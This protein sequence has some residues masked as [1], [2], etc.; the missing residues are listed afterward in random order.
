MESLANIQEIRR[1]ILETIAKPS[2]GYSIGNLKHTVIKSEDQNRFLVVRT[3]WY[4]GKNYYGIM[5]DI[6]LQD[7][8]VLIHKNG[9]DEELAEELEEAG[10]PANAIIKSYQQ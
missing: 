1:I 6:E 10:V 5:Q 2:G 8:K 9:A 3:G 4:Q 7:G